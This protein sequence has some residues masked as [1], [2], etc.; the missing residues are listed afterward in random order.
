MTRSGLKSL[1]KRLVDK[2]VIKKQ[3]LGK[4]TIYL[5]K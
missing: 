5:I 4:G 1:L 3:G 2:G